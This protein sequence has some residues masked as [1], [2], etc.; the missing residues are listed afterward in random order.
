MKAKQG[1]KVMDGAEQFLEDGER[2]VAGIVAAARGNTIAKASGIAAARGIGSQIAGKQTSAAGAAGLVVESPM[3]LVATDRRL[4]T[5]K[6]TTPWGFGMGGTVK[7]LLSSVPLSAVESIEVK[8]L[9]VGRSIHLTV[10]GSEFKLECGAGADAQGLA[11]AVE[12]GRP[13]TA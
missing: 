10:N 4:L 5:L 11:D 13:V 1:Q 8:R 9:G 6:I 12:Q 3:G 2:V 7:D